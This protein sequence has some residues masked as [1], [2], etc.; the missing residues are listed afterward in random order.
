MKVHFRE[1]GVKMNRK[2][3]RKMLEDVVLPLNVAM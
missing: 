1:K 3:Y 2:V